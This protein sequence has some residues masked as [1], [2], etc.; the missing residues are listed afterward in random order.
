MEP[1][2]Q[3]QPINPVEAR[4]FAEPPQPLDLRPRPQPKRPLDLRPRPEQQPLDLRPKPSQPAQQPMRLPRLGMPEEATQ[5][6]NN[7]LNNPMGYAPA[8]AVTAPLAFANRTRELHRQLSTPETMRTMDVPTIP[9]PADSFPDLETT[10]TNK[11][12][13]DAING[14]ENDAPV[15]APIQGNSGGVPGVTYRVVMYRVDLGHHYEFLTGFVT[16]PYSTYWYYYL[17]R[18]AP[19]LE[20]EAST[21]FR[22]TPNY[23]ITWVYA[24]DVDEY[25]FIAEPLTPPPP[26][27]R[28]NR[29][30]QPFPGG[31]P[32]FVEMPE[33]DLPGWQ[34][35]RRLNLV[36]APTGEIVPYRPPEWEPDPGEPYLPPDH[37]RT[38]GFPTAPDLENP[39]GQQPQDD[40]TGKGT[41]APPWWDAWR[42]WEPPDQWTNRKRNPPR[43]RDP[44]L[45]GPQTP[46]QLPPVA[47]VPYDGCCIE[48]LNR[49]R[50][51]QRRLEKLEV[52]S[53]I[54]A[55]SCDTTADPPTPT[56]DRKQAKDLATAITLIGESLGLI[57]QQFAIC[58]PAPIDQADHSQIAND[59]ATES[60]TVWY[61]PLASEVRQVE[62]I[63]TGELP[64]SFRLY[65]TSADGE[66][67]AKFGA[68]ALSC[69]GVTGGN[70]ANS[71]HQWCWTRRTSMY[72]GHRSPRENFLRVYIRSGLSW[73]LYDTGLRE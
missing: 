1:Q 54:P 37:R 62:L 11:L 20:G 27:P 28:P 18:A 51:I 31:F 66:Q 3:L 19:G 6:W 35:E 21:G 10:P 12:S 9:L 52:D 5:G 69:A 40:P 44:Q 49:L 41:L 14:A 43:Q 64:K 71:F 45:P 23:G 32:D 72:V 59:T 68:L 58:P 34:P 70:T 56:E 36:P 8:K 4:P 60:K 63:I 15:A 55:W 13:P 48:T 42:D 24:T 65:D 29:A 25:A 30:R 16:G 46:T 17:N 22:T 39:P 38:P 2:P 7:V 67:Q 33:L 57:Q 73:V 50:D 61:I 47:V 53:E 26:Q